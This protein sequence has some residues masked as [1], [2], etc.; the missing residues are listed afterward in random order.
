MGNR[1]HGENAGKRRSPLKILLVIMAGTLGVFAIAFFAYASDYYRADETALAA[2]TGASA[3]ESGQ[4]QGQDLD[5]VRVVEEPGAIAFIPRDA[6]AAFAFYPGGKVEFAAYAPL[7]RA[8]ADHGLACVVME[9]PFN[10]AFFGIDAADDA[11]ALLM[12]AGV[13]A[14]LP[15]YLGGHSLGGVAAALHAAENAADYEGLV[16]LASYSTVDLSGVDLDVMS[17]YGSNDQ[18]LDAAAYAES[19]SNLGE[20]VVELVI[21]GGNHAQFG[22]YGAQDGDGAATISADEQ[23]EQTADFLAAQML[24]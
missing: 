4:A 15:C 20:N 9:M 23:I 19:F 22:S 18:V 24:A 5:D 21:E 12:E 3:S 17:V 2:L 1:H 11:R 8:L 10:L 6:K 13:P 16:L 14:D 7:L